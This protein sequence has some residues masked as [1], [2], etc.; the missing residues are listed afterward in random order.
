[1]TRPRGDSPA[2]AESGLP[3]RGEAGVP[4]KVNLSSKLA[5]FQELW[6]PKAIGAVNDFHVKLVKLKGEFVWHSH[7]TEDELFLVLRGRLRMQFRDGEVV[8]EP[9]ELIIVPHRTE[10]RPV[11]DD[12]AHVLLLEPGSTVNTGT[13]GGDRTRDVDWI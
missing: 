5:L 9:G 12:E 4:R 10:H 6:S 2:A 11:A 7:E 1:V 8:V 13:A 3:E